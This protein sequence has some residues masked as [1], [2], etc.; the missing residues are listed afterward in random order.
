M[1]HAGALGAEARM[2][3]MQGMQEGMQ[4]M[5]F[6]DFSLSHEQ[7]VSCRPESYTHLS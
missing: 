2:Q 6:L 5:H 3:G 4:G 7:D 1:P